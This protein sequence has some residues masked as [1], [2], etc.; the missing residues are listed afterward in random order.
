MLTDIRVVDGTTFA[1]VAKEARTLAEQYG[2][3]MIGTRFWF[4]NDMFQ[5][6]KKALVLQQAE[7]I[8]KQW[9]KEGKTRS[10]LLKEF[11]QFL[12]NGS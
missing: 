12:E 11:E 8:T 9:E 6:F 2:V 1:G 3:H 4:K 5:A 10:E 7:A